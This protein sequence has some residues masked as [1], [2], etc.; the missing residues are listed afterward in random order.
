M[1]FTYFK[2]N[3]EHE[4]DWEDDPNDLSVFVV[5]AAKLEHEFGLS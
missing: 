1:V 3:F 5:I 4:L 2:I